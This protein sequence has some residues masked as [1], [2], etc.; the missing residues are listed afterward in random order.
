MA[1]ERI[2]IVEDNEK[3]IKLLRDV[4]A[5]HGYRTIEARSGEEAIT[6]AR[7]ERPQLVL[8]DIQLP[9]MD[10]VTALRALR[11]LPETAAVPVLA[12]TAFAMKHDRER[13]LAAGFDDYV[14]KPIDIRGLPARVGSYLGSPPSET[15]A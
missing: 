13:L 12:V 8:M 15:E 1:G 3:N 7:A 5:A 2:L 14:E 6:I 11:E 10:G 9:K 4:L